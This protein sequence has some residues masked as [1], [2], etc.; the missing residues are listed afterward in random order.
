MEAHLVLLQLPDAERQ[1][2][3][4]QQSVQNQNQGADPPPP[5]G[6]GAR[7]DAARP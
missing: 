6:A 3:E 7:H 2:G 5:L 4:Q 1:H